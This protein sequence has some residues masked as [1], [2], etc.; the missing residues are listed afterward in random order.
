VLLQ[1]CCV[2][3][4]VSLAAEIPPYISRLANFLSSNVHRSV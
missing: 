1:L 3:Y 4:A 2:R